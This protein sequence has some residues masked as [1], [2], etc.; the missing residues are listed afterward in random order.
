[1]RIGL[2]LDLSSMQPVRPQLNAFA[3]MLERA[4]DRGFD[5]VWVG[6]SYHRTPQAFHLPASL[7]VLAHLAGRT[8]LPLGTAVL[9]LRA[10]PIE[11]LCYEAALLDQLCE[12]KF[13]LGLGLGAPELAE[14]LGS[15]VTGSAGSAFDAAIAT[16]RSAWSSKPHMA[17][18]QPIRAGGPKILVGGKTAASVRRAAQLGDGFYGA[19]NYTDDLLLKQTAAYRSMRE[20][21][22]TIATT[23]FCLVHEDSARAKSLAT[24]HFAAAVDYYTSRHAWVGATGKA[25]PEFPFVGSPD[26]VNAAIRT[27]AAA[28]V[29]SLQLRVSPFG[30][31]PRV[32]DHTIDLVGKEVLPVWH[33]EE[34]DR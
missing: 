31:P 9:L 5:S 23:R 12:G 22:G 10:Y 30:T 13:T 4:E 32:A 16:L 25:G 8:R 28:G 18:P 33:K 34:A 21:G 20:S 27:Y 24:S 1:M 26:E 29:T 14:R 7:M 19:T 17:I 11:R 6:E 15:P 3:A 2:A